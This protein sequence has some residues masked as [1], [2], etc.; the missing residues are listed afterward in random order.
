MKIDG[1]NKYFFKKAVLKAAAIVALASSATGVIAGTVVVK[2][3]AQNTF[4][5]EFARALARS[6]TYTVA[7]ALQET[8]TIPGEAPF[9]GSSIGSQGAVYLFNGTSTTAERIYQFPGNSYFMFKAGAQVAISDKWLSFTSANVSNPNST[10]KSATFIVGKPNGVWG[11]CPTVNGVI[12]CTSVVSLNG[13]SP[14]LPIIKIPFTDRLSENDTNVAI[15][16]NYLVTADLKNSILTFYRYDTATVKW[17]QEFYID[18]PD[19]RRTGTAIAIDGDRIAVSSPYTFGA[20]SKGSVRL[21]KRNSVTQTW[22]ATANAYGQF[23]DGQFGKALD[24]HSNNLVVSAGSSAHLA[25]YR[26]TSNDTLSTPQIVTTSTVIPSVAVYGDVI[27]AGT[28][29]PNKAVQIY[30]RNTSNNIWSSL[31]ALNGTIYTSTNPAGSAYPGADEVDLFGDNLSLGWRNYK[32]NVGGFINEK[33]SLIDSCKNPKNL[34][35]NCAFDNNSG[36]GWL[37]LNNQGASGSVSYSGNQLKVTINNPGSIHWHIQSRTAV[38]L[39]AAQTYNVQFRAKS[40]GFRQFTVN[41]G[42]NGNQ[43]NNWLSYGS[44]LV[45]TNTEWAQYSVNFTAPADVNA[46]LD[47]NFGNQGTLGVTVDGV[48]LT[49]VTP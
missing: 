22:V 25:F 44:S 27:A 6:N 49:P 30:T 4:A 35:G 17:V 13:A 40:D 39:P 29:E 7:A 47:L 3:G 9:L 8:I 31:N 45:S 14:V 1:L 21:F 34:V 43:D 33:V 20:P 18:E 36:A 38:S 41:L 26:V 37:F 42:H 2:P 11:Q 23:T 15:S 46:Y 24:L 5:P 12:D 28:A 19:D 32:S 16:D 10:D 48:S